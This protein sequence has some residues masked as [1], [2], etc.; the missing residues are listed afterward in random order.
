VATVTLQHWAVVTVMGYHWAV[1][2][3]MA[4]HWAVVTV[5]GWGAWRP[6]CWAV[7]VGLWLVQELALVLG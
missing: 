5:M 6:W 7:A 3:V 4:Y 2:T 1:V